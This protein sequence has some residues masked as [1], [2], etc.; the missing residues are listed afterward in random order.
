MTQPDAP[1]EAGRAAD[2]T[3]NRMPPPLRVVEG[4]IETRLRQLLR[5]MTRESTP[6]LTQMLER[7]R[8]RAPLRIVRN[9]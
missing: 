3:P 2:P 6:E 7:L 5:L 9:D 1:G 8:Y 4:D